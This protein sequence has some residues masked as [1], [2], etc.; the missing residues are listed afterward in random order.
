MLFSFSA[1]LPIARAIL[2]IAS[3]LA[4]QTSA[5]P[6]ELVGLTHSLPTV[7]SLSFAS[8]VCRETMCSAKGYGIGARVA[9]RAGGTAWD[10]RQ[11]RVWVSNG[12]TLA[13]LNVHGTRTL[14]KLACKP[15]A[16]PLPAGTTTRYVTGLEFVEA[17][18][19]PKPGVPGP[20]GRLFLSYN[21]QTLGWLDVRGCALGKPSFCSL[22]GYLGTRRI[23]GGLAADD[24]RGFLFIATSSAVATSPAN[25]IY[26][27]SI[28]KP[29]AVICKFAVTV[30]QQKCANV[31]LGPITGLA[32]DGCSNALYIT[33]GRVMMYGKIQVTTNPVSCRFV[34]GGCCARTATEQFVGLAVKPT[35]PSSHGVAC[36]NGDCVRCPTMVGGTV[37]DPVL[38]NGDFAFTLGRAPANFTTAILAIGFGPCTSGVS[39]GFCG[40]VRIAFGPYRPLVLAF[41]NPRPGTNCLGEMRVPVAIPVNRGLCG[42]N[43]SVQWIVAC[44]R[45]GT[46][47]TPCVTMKVQGI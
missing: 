44:P 28:E 46:G 42:L 9:A 34:H 23:I 10:G 39:L 41:G 47:V 14:C 27:T 37:G 8:G 38:G 15:V 20:S 45:G 4:G 24:A 30:D 32:Y 22:L 18:V 31:R 21:N 7:A 6:A 1:K 43:M 5:M 12:S 36:T 19:Q 29:C 16:A 2:G 11:S 26:I 33:D 25:V 17:G 35:Q 13:L 40:P 3:A